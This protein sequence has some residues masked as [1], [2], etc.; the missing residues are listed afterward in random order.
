MRDEKGVT[1]E[2]KKWRQQLNRDVDVQKS[3][4]LFVCVFEDYVV[5][6]LDFLR[7]LL[8]RRETDL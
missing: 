6:R 4:S 1:E 2:V 8:V 3:L 7:D 5:L